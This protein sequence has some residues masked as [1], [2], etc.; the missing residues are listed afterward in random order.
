MELDKPLQVLDLGLLDLDGQEGHEP[1]EID[2]AAVP[3]HDLVHHRLH[4]LDR[5]VQAYRTHHHY[6]LLSR[7][8]AI[9][10]LVEK[11]ESV[12]QLISSLG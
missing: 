10:V 4:L 12:L 9:A 5:A 6:Q 3:L 8:C 11:V 1:L 7:D 2:L